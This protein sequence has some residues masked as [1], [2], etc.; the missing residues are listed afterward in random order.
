MNERSFDLFELELFQAVAKAGSLSAAS[1]LIDLPISSISRR[2]KHL[3]DRAKVKLFERKPTGL[4]LTEAGHYL[5]KRCDVILAEFDTTFSNLNQHS[6]MPSGR[7]VVHCPPGS[8]TYVF[9][10]FLRL[11]QQK[12]PDIELDI[13]STLGNVSFS[14]ERIDVFLHPG[15]LPDTNVIAKPLIVTQLDYFASPGYIAEHGLPRS[16][17]ELKKH[18]FILFSPFVKAPGNWGF[19]KEK[20]LITGKA[21]LVS[22]DFQLCIQEIKAG[23]GV[24]ILPVQFVVSAVKKQELVPLFNGEYQRN[25]PSYVVIPSRGYVPEK[26][27]I[28]VDELSAYAKGLEHKVVV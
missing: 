23:S 19:S 26:L 27:K 20:P 3:E 12:Y 7:I 16:P 24:G 4:D 22:D 1:V 6:S 11:F 18:K 21:Q 14:D 17:D 13:I 8:F 28:F 10:E 5:V 25:H 9:P 15:E 2:I